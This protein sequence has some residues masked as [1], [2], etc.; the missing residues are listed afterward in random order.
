MAQILEKRVAYRSLLAFSD[1]D[2]G[3]DRLHHQIGRREGRQ[4][5]Q[6]HAVR[7]LVDDVIRKAHGQTR[8]SGAARARQRHQAR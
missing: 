4:I 3:R 1:A 2:G 5:D 7:K 8:L 6:P